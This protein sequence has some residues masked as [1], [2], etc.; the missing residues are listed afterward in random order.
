ML[1]Y[2]PTTLQLIKEPFAIHQRQTTSPSVTELQELFSSMCGAFERVYIVLDGLDEA[3]EEV[4]IQLLEG[5]NAFPSNT[6]TLIMSRP[7][8]SFE[9]LV[10]G[11][12]LIDIEAR[13]ED[14]ELFVEKKIAQ[15]PRL[16]M[17][18]AGT[19]GEKRRICKTIREKSGGM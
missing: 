8:K 12:V 9:C 2:D 13:N 16:R 19:E 3:Q 18:L 11:V 6:R 4:K 1:E 17:V 7:L 5:I 10:P 15:M 14:I